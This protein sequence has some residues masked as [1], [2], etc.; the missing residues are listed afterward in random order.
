MQRETKYNLIGQRFGKLVVID[1][2]ED[3]EREWNGK[4]T[5]QVAW[6]CKCDCGN[7]KI[8][9]QGSLLSGNTKTCGNKEC[10][11]GRRV[12]RNKYDLSGEF[13]RGWTKSGVEFWFDKEDYDLIKDY[14]WGTD[15]KGYIEAIMWDNTDGSQHKIKL[16]RLVMNVLD[17]KDFNC[18]V[19]HRDRNRLDNR[20][21]NLR[22]V[23]NA[24][25]NANKNP[26]REDGSKIVWH[27]IHVSYKCSICGIQIDKS[28]WSNPIQTHSDIP[29]NHFLFDYL[30]INVNKC[31]FVF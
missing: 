22:I 14:N 23:D 7:T 28:I 11:K 25:N 20:K 15:E 30:I 24:T 3:I 1:R 21:E 2:A 18:Q 17:N 19:D 26:Y 27:I 10:R 6:L 31:C 13:G 29:L 4:H 12:I 5:S 9:Y 8:A 16:S